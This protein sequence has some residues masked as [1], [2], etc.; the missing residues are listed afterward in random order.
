[1]LLTVDPASPV[2]LYEQLAA[3]VRVAHEAGELREG[4]RLPPARQLAGD[5]DVN[6]HT[7]LRAYD[8]L[9]T[10]G[11]IELHRRRGAVVTA[12]PGP[13]LPP[14]VQQALDRLVTL[15]DRHGV[16]VADLRSAL[17]EGSR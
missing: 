17:S 16:S 9:R 3:C 10:E 8:V 15:A 11:L 12:S 13:A 7:V 2:P 5:L 1:M 14:A 6:M 4:D